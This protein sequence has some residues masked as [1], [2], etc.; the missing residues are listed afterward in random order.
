M[1]AALSRRPTSRNQVNASPSRTLTDLLPEELELFALESG[2]PAYRGR[3]LAEA[4]YVQNVPDLHAM[5]VLPKELRE[6]W[7]AEPGVA[8]LLV[9]ESIPAPDRSIKY[10]LEL[11]DG[12]RVEA[13][14]MPRE[15]GNFTLCLSSQVGCRMACVFCATGRMGIIRQLTTAEIV[16]QVRLLT[17]LNPGKSKPNLVFMGMGEPFDNLEALLPAL[18]IL[19]HE[20][21]L[22]IGARRITVSTSGLVDGI[23]ALRTLERP[24]GLAISLTTANESERRAWMPVAGQIPLD[25]LLAAAA[26]YGRQHRRK[27][28]LECAIIGGKNDSMEHAERLRR[29][30]SGGPFKVNLIPL[31]PIDH[32][33]GTRPDDDRIGAM[34]DH[35]WQRGIVATVR[36]SRGRQVEGACGQLAHRQQRRAGAPRTPAIA[37]DSKVEN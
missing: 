13:V 37:R 21:G 17:R 32:F 20:R 23:A 29:I 12:A 19:M 25:E 8:T 14:A 9:T 24:I 2:E 4:L 22:A 15:D 1:G 33:E 3:Q 36:D 18:R 35:L 34:V 26:D 7:T 5:T 11:G 28:T 30:A 16:E 31:N 27:V 6:R 10:L